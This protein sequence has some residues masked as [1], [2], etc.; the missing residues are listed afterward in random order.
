VVRS[1][2]IR[3]FHPGVHVPDSNRRKSKSWRTTY[4]GES[5]RERPGAFARENHIKPYTLGISK[6]DF[7][8]NTTTRIR[9]VYITRLVTGTVNKYVQNRSRT[10]YSTA[11][12]FTR[13]TDGYSFNIAARSP[14]RSVEFRVSV[15]LSP[16][17]KR[18]TPFSEYYGVGA[19][20][21][22]R[23][24]STISGIRRRPI[25]GYDYREYRARIVKPDRSGGVCFN[26]YDVYILE[27]FSGSTDYRVVTLEV[28]SPPFISYEQKRA[29]PYV[30]FGREHT[31][32]IFSLYVRRTRLY[33]I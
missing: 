1:C 29:P 21:N 14:K 30:S 13:K 6:Y 12:I 22:E 32:V 28:F 5:R 16:W 24:C 2:V 11:V 15:R 17:R 3:R 33:D 26:N 18:V 31:R 7:S 27:P 10:N 19:S 8:S 4:R 25:N 23:G 9:S 20:L